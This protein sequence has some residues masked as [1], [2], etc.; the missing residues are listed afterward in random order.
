[1][2]E[3]RHSLFTGSPD[4]QDI[5]LCTLNKVVEHLEDPVNLIRQASTSLVPSWG[6]L[7]VEV[8][9]KE[10]IV[11]RP[12]ADNILGALHRQLYDFRSLDCAFRGAGMVAIQLE[13]IYEPSGKISIAGFAVMPDAISILQGKDK[14]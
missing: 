10:T 7:Y 6:V 3:V 2:F 8:P 5:D 13:R 11:C 4:V 12:P 1:M 9:A 14:M